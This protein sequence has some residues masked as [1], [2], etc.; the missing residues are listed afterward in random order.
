MNAALTLLQGKAC[1]GPR[2]CCQ[3]AVRDKHPRNMQFA[4]VKPPTASRLAGEIYLAALQRQSVAVCGPGMSHDLSQSDALLWIFAQHARD[5]VLEAGGQCRLVGRE[6][7]G[8]SA[9]DIVQPHDAGVLE[10]YS[11]CIAPSLSA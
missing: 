11:S 7:D 5:E 1:V 2:P 9:D 8:L 6:G 10:R 3:E 4:R